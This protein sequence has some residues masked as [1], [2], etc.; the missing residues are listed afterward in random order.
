MHYIIS[1]LLLQP[2]FLIANDAQQHW[3]LDLLS[4]ICQDLSYDRTFATYNVLPLF[5]LFVWQ[6]FIMCLWAWT[7]PLQKTLPWLFYL[8]TDPSLH[9]NF[10]LN[11]FSAWIFSK[12]SNYFIFLNI[13]LLHNI[14]S[15]MKSDKVH[16]WII[17]KTIL[18]IKN[19][20]CGNIINYFHFYCWS[21]VF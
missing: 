19:N 13:H 11:L 9:S 6:F 7:S 1:L 16:T 17:L 3:H 10:T 8:N 12:K 4:Q 20:L 14:V 18:C 21:I 2:S 15:S 5:L